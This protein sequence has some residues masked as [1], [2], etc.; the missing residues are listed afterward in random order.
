MNAAQTGSISRAN[1]SDRFLAAE[2][3]VSGLS[4]LA[5]VSVHAGFRPSKMIEWE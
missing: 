2:M 3:T 5:E 1:K 4:E